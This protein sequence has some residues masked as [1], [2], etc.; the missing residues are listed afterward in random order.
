MCIRDRS[1]TYNIS[2][3]G[4]SQNTIRLLT[5]TNNPTSNPAPNNFVEGAIANTIFNSANSLTDGGT[6]NLVLT[7]RNGGSGFDATYGGVRQLAFTDN[8]NM[9]LRG[10]GTGVTTWGSWGKV[11]TSLNDGVDSGLDADRFDNRQGAWYQNA[12]NINFGTLS[13][14]RLPRFLSP[15]VFN[16]TV[17]IKSF[18]G[19]PKYEIYV[20]GLILNTS[21]WIPGNPVNLYNSNSQAVGSFTIDNISINDDV[22]DNF[23]DYTI[24]IGRL[25][26]GNFVGAETIGTASNRV[27]F[28]DFTIQD[29]NTYEVA[30]LY[31]NGGQGLLELG[32][33]DGQ[34]TS[35]SIYFHS[36]ASAASNYNV[37][38]IAQGGNTTDGSGTLDIQVVNADGLSINGNTA[39]NAGNIVF[40]SANIASTAVKRDASGNFS[41]GTITA[42][43]VGASSLNVLKT[44]DTMTGTLNITG[45]GSNLS[46]SNNLSVTGTTTLT[47]DLNVDAGSLYVDVSQNNVGIG[48]TSPSS[49]VKLDVRGS[50]RIGTFSQSQTTVSY[51][52]LTLPTTPYV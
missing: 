31:S 26:S 27:T 41:A 2:I 6:R 7:L 8:D 40:Q 46:V 38:L 21:P 37:A 42:S 5:G 17:T 30:K 45:A 16:N 10:S 25:T 35:P 24:L 49:A 50:I 28:H 20:S 1:G 15:T 12:L 34:A 39:W 13:D 4:Q 19:D 22:G 52:H 18:L 48:T 29:G 11:W 47:D 32:R 23:N 3:S 33:S 36:S 44:G 9:W 51:T 43:I 14:N